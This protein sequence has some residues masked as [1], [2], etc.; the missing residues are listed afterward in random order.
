MRDVTCIALDDESL[1]ISYLADFIRKTPF[2]TL[3]GCFEKPTEAWAF[4]EA[5]SVDL[6]ISDIAMPDISGVALLKNLK[7]PPLFIFVTANAD[8][9]AESYELDV[10]DYIVKPYDYARFLKAVRKAQDQLNSKNS[11]SI[12]KEKD[13]ITVKDGYK[14]VIIRFDEIFYIEGSKE[15]VA[16]STLEKDVIFRKSLIQMEQ[17]LPPDKFIR[18]QKSYIVNTDFVRELTVSKIIMRGGIKDIPL[19]AQYRAELFRRFGLE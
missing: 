11:P 5:E 6:V 4:L 2:L 15:Y 10:V 17:L 18:V 3:K 12:K 16:I 13:F 19:G 14:N 9:A 7:N 8:F 1:A